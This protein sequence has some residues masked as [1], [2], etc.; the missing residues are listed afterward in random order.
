MLILANRWPAA[1][2]QVFGLSATAFNPREAIVELIADHLL[3]V[4]DEAHCFGDEVLMSA[5]GPSDPGAVA[6]GFESERGRVRALERPGEINLDVDKLGRS[7]LDE[8]H[9][10][11]ADL[12]VADP[13]KSRALA[14]RRA[15]VADLGVG[16][17][18]RPRRPRL[19]LVQVVD[20]SEYRG[21]WRGDGCLTL[22]V[23]LRGLQR[24]HPA[25]PAMSSTTAI[26]IFLS[27]D[28]SG[29]DL[30]SLSPPRQSG[31]T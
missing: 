15:L 17:E 3:A 10:P 14:G 16:I 28:V 21:R 8:S 12:V 13:G 20:V 1:G 4:E 23:E 5:H 26:K 7:A 30:G 25:K 6:R 27:I 2:P 19:P 9:T 18:L 29:R 31:K 22:D 11:F 24:D